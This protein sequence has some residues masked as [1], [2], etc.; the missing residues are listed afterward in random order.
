MSSSF[1]EKAHSG[2]MKRP[3]TKINPGP[4]I[5]L[6]AFVGFMGAL[7]ILL[8]ERHKRLTGGV[9]MIANEDPLTPAQVRR[10]PYLNTGSK[11]AGADPDW[12]WQRTAGS[13]TRASDQRSSMSRIPTRA[14]SPARA[15]TRRVSGSQLR[16]CAYRHS[17][18]DA[19]FEAT[20]G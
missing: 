11:D 13:L 1:W 15:T 3:P 10:G 2:K 14:S 6:F 9:P 18:A 19:C 20:N 17:T 7:P 8:S 16:R 5:G 12:Q 4:V